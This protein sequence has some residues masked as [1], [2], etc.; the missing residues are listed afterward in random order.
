ME[1]IAPG[2]KGALLPEWRGGRTMRVIEGGAIAIADPVSIELI[3][4]REAI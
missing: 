4:Y 3:D 1:G 2:L